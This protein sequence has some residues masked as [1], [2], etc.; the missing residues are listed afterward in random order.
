[1][2]PA[3]LNPASELPRIQT[4][5]PTINRQILGIELGFP[6]QNLCPNFHP[7]FFRA[8]SHLLYIFHNI[9]ITFKLLLCNFNYILFSSCPIN[10]CR[11]ILIDSQS[12]YTDPQWTSTL[13][14]HRNVQILDRAEA[15]G[16][17]TSQQPNT[18][19]IRTS[20]Y[21]IVQKRAEAGGYQPFH[22]SRS[23]HIVVLIKGSV[24]N[25]L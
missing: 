12:L 6:I 16:S 19:I 2:P 20:E 4:R 15:C 3:A 25:L 14:H 21:Q 17:G 8:A 13:W 7:F 24:S 23:Y 18:S 22:N 9:L 11:S 10:G 5:S 1:M